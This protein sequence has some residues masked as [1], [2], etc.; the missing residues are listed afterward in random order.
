MINRL[1]SSIFTINSHMNRVGWQFQ[2]EEVDRAIGNLSPREFFDFQEEIHI[3]I[4]PYLS[5]FH[6]SWLFEVCWAD[7]DCLEHMGDGPPENYDREVPLNR[8][9]RWAISDAASDRL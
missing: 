6:V 3:D 5:A 4:S 8:V 7:P 9:K 1:K 2:S